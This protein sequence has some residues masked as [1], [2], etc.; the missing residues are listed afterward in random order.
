MPGAVHL[1]LER[2]RRRRRHGLAGFFSG[3][4]PHRPSFSGEVVVGRS[5]I[6]GFNST[7]GIVW[8]RD[9]MQ[10]S[11]NCL[12]QV[13]ERITESASFTFY[14]LVSLFTPAVPILSREYGTCSFLL[15][16]VLYQVIFT[17]F[18]RLEL[19][20]LRAK[21]VYNI[22]RLFGLRI[23][24]S[25][26]KWRRTKHNENMLQKQPNIAIGIKLKKYAVTV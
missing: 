4:A 26:Q 1:E 15:S 2:I 25:V 12:Y 16:F 13:G 11:K 23:T 22:R 5:R 9:D 14:P 3:L 18:R 20:Q 19:T 7:R 17:T 21:R 10:S 8:R 24:H 6:L